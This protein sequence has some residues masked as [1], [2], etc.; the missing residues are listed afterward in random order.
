MAVMSDSQHKPTPAP[1]LSHLDAE[2]RPRMVDVGAKAVTRR[3]A[4]AQALVCFPEPV[5]AQLR[6]AQFRGGKAGAKGAIIDTAVIAGTMAV[7]RTHELIPFCHPLPVERIGIVIEPRAD[8]P[9]LAITCQVAVSGRTGVEM[10][11]L[12]GASV[13]ALTLYDMCK[14]LSQ[15]IRIDS[16]RLLAKSGGRHDY[17]AKETDDGR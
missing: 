9:V 17:Q 12:T 2:G 13:A 16:L 11:A 7:K 6:D 1:G 10:E 4:V 3:V 15:Q 14:A 5:F 8:E